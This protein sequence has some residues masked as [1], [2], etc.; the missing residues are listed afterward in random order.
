MRIV[1]PQVFSIFV[2]LGKLSKKYEETDFLYAL[3][4]SE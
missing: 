1:R 4:L 3:F 2:F